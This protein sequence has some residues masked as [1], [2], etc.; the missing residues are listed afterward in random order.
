MRVVRLLEDGRLLQENGSALP[1]PLR[2]DALLGCT[3][4]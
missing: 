2:Y 3:D 1:R 4:H